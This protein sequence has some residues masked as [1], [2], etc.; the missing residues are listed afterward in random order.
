MGDKKYNMI[1]GDG[2]EYGPY[3]LDELRDFLHQGRLNMEYQVREDDLLGEWQAVSEVLKSRGPANYDDL[4]DAL[5]ESDHRFEIGVAFGEGWEAFKGN[6]LM[7]WGA[8]ILYMVILMGVSL[9]PIIGGIIQFVIQGALTGGLIILVLNILRDGEAK[10]E[11]LFEGFKNSFGS[12]F[13][14]NLLHMLI[15]F[16]FI[17]PGLVLI[18][19][20]I[21]PRFSGVDLENEEAV[22]EALVSAFFDPILIGGFVLMIMLSWVAYTLIYWA[23]PLVADKRLEVMESFKLSF[24]I[25]KRNFFCIVLFYIATFFLTIVSMIPLGLGLFITVPWILAAWMNCYEQMFSPEY[26]E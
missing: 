9:I 25:A 18:L 3:T 20:R 2:N 15:S 19:I 13:L 23:L 5:L 7:L 24:K 8:L 1:G 17:I 11:D 26:N 16:I 6:F 4:E 22:G 14:V 10:I 12:L 21:I